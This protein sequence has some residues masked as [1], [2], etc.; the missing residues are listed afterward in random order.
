MFLAAILVLLPWVR[1]V[2]VQKHDPSLSC[3][4][5]PHAPLYREELQLKTRSDKLKCKDG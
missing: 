5:R 2:R 3:L 1:A 4:T